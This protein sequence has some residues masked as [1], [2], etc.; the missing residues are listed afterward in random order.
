MRLDRGGKWK[1]SYWQMTP[2]MPK[3]ALR[4][5]FELAPP[6]PRLREIELRLAALRE[7]MEKQFIVRLDN[8][9]RHTP[10]ER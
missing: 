1:S 2:D 10:T 9:R 4:T 8:G 6:D 5:I 3:F 7:Y